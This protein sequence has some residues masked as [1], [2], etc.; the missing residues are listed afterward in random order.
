MSQRNISSIARAEA[1]A[2]LTSTE[3]L[4]QRLV[5]VRGRAWLLLLVAGL[6]VA[7]CVTWGF[8]GRLPRVV[9]GEGVIAPD[10]TQP[11]EIASPAAVGGVV[12][13]IVPVHERVK[14]GEPLV[15]L[16][17]RELEVEFENATARVE[18][19][20]SQ[21][22]RLT[23]AED[24]ILARRKTSME[25]RVAAANRTADQ[26]RKLVAMLETELDDLKSLVDDQLVPRSQYVSTQQNYFGVLQQLA[27]Q[28][29]IID[30]ARVDYESLVTSTDQARL[31]RA[32]TL[33]EARDTRRSAETNLA[34][35]TV[36]LAPISGE[37]LEHMVDRGSTVAVGT[38]VTSIRPDARGEGGLRAQ[39]FVPYGTGRRVRAGMKAQI[40]LPFAPPSRY[41]Y[42]LGEVESVSTFVA[43]GS[44]S[45]HL[46]SRE[47]AEQMARELGPML[48]VR[49]RLDTDD[50][51]PT[52]LRWTSAGGYEGELAF[53][54]LCG[55]RVVVSEE[56][57]IDL[58]LP[59]IKD[60]LGL[61][62]PVEVTGAPG[63]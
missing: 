52:G 3:Q 33:A 45:V 7:L 8:L 43:G 44:A 2:Q 11:V 31:A 61:D 14:E 59:W 1:V 60:L 12:E 47:L 40:S 29:T 30:Q 50:S 49:V 46:G 37:V 19:L 20:E 55:V 35:S 32:S 58:V 23:E 26:T 9:A 63:G 13:L 10:G 42:I 24:R 34:V 57:P 28:E 4:D 17:N 62:P 27:Q 15:K 16:H 22:R 21:D 41:G 18:M 56:R 36:V 54:A 5:V 25:A 48:E 38:A 51:T 39:V 6:L 53:P